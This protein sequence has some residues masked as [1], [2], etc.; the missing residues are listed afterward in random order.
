MKPA[1]VLA[2]AFL[3][4]LVPVPGAGLA[5]AQGAGQNQGSPL[6]SGDPVPE[7]AVAA[8]DGIPV[9]VAAFLDEMCSRYVRPSSEGLKALEALEQEALVGAAL[10]R[11]DLE[12]TD[13]ELEEK[14]AALGE[15]LLKQT[16]KSLEQ[17]LRE[18][19]VSSDTFRAKTR[20][21]VSLEKLVRLEQNV[22]AGR[23]VENL[24]LKLWLEQ[25]R[26]AAKIE[27]DPAKLPPEAVSLVDG[28][29]VLKSAFV[30]TL[31]ATVPPE[32]IRRNVET[33][34]QEV[35]ARRLLAAHQRTLTEA[36]VMAEWLYKK[37]EFESDPMH[38][39]IGYEEIIKQQTGLEP[40]AFRNSR[41]FRVNAAIGQL[42][43]VVFTPAQVQE[44]WTTHQDLYGP[45]LHCRHILLRASDHP[46][47]KGKVRTIAEGRELAHFILGK[48]KDGASF[49]DLARQYSEDQGTKFRG[50][51][52][53]VF[54]PGRH[55]FEKAFGEACVR[56]EAY[57]LSEPV[58]TNSG[59]HVIRC[60]SKDPAPSLAEVEA[61]LRRV[62]AAEHFRAEF[63]KA[64]VSVDATKF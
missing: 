31:L 61:D 35:L 32:E 53:P 10:R 12:V 52:L 58:Q 13:A 48:A 45:R 20:S 30:R 7:G 22:P 15:Q 49:E 16:G 42:A 4:G 14:I 19:K 46:N 26:S 33:L 39:G 41:G 43:L 3:A 8:L 40:E 60:D 62:L 18:T 50:G 63:S 36:S 29:R 44:A 23:P 55:A 9:P 64:R 57:G 6:K 59:W 5:P 2:A 28:E 21:V 11:R 27:R 47:V 51:L 34:L 24:Q 17:T 25:A 1:A 37:K 54:T 56:L 38:Q